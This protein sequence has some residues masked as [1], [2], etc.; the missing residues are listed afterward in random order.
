MSDWMD[1]AACKGQTHLFFAPP[2]ERPPSR[3]RREAQAVALCKVCPV[4]QHC[5]AYATAQA[6]EYGIWGGIALKA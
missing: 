6:E 2:G 4:A 1:S 5:A 3:E